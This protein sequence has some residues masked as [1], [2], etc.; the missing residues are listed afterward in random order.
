M[1]HGEATRPHFR[2]R[3]SAS[4]ITR[5]RAKIMNSHR[6]LG[7]GERRERGNRGETIKLTHR[8]VMSILSR[9]QFLSIIASTAE[10]YEKL[11]LGRER[12]LRRR[13]VCARVSPVPCQ[14]RIINCARP[15]RRTS[16][17]PRTGSAA[18][19]R[20][21][22]RFS[23]EMAPRSE[24]FSEGIFDAETARYARRVNWIA[25]LKRSRSRAHACTH[26]C[27]HLDNSAL[28][29]RAAERT[30]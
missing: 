22:S 17:A 1:T 4:G 18:R 6:T 20:G 28:R 29:E 14:L 9:S 3:A 26:A 30:F 5:M 2:S 10:I 11:L 21:A 7:E 15:D 8:I 12:K 13:V 19:H 16:L 25:I 27:T 23:H 24:R